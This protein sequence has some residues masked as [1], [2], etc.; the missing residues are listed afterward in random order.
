MD[1]IENRKCEGLNKYEIKYW[2]ER[3]GSFPLE[4]VEVV[5]HSASYEM[6]K[7]HILK[8]ESGQYALVTESGCS[9]YSAEDADIELFPDLKSAKESFANWVKE[10]PRAD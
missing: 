9:C 4:Q 1:K 10:H 8:L 7:A 5:D 3:L 6:T 2:L